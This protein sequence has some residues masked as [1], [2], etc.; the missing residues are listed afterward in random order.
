MTDVAK[1]DDNRVPVGL[2]VGN[3]I[4]AEVLNL[5]LD[6]ATKRLLVDAIVEIQGYGEV[7]D[8]IKIVTTAATRVQ[9]DNVTVKKVFIQANDSNTGTLVV[10]GSTVVAAAGTRRG[11]ALFPG[12]GD[13]FQVSNLNLL[14]IDSTENGDKINYIYLL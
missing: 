14:Y 7:G 9:L 4:D 5:L 8:G 3:D 11:L 6:S 13:W 1:R 2:G 10:G 12:Q